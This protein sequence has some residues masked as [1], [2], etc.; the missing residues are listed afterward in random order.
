MEW[1]FKTEG[2]WQN[3]IIRVSLG[4]VM[5]AHGAL[6][7]G[8]VS[9]TLAAFAQNFHVPAA[10]AVLV[11]AAESLG[12]LGLIAGFATRFC[13]FG[14]FCDMLGAIF[15]VHWHNG[16]FMNWFGKQQGEGF[17]YHILAIGMALALMI[18]GGGRLSLDRL[19]AQKLY[20]PGI[21]L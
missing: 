3:T 20:R 1:F 13:A 14:I 7:L 5:F 11:I 15:I 16:F 19:I 10:L 9:D 2:G 21:R 17:E 4:G 18:S 8:S 6:K 12:A